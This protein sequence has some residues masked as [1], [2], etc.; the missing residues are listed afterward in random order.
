M[1]T[2]FIKKRKED[3]GVSPDD[4]IFRGEANVN[5]VALNSIEYN[6]QELIESDIKQTQLN[7]LNKE[8]HITWLNVDS[9]HDIDLLEDITSSF[10]IDQL[11]MSEVLNVHSRPRLIDYGTGTLISIRMLQVDEE[12]RIKAENLSLVFTKSI[13]IS[14][15]E[16]PGDVF[17]PIRERLRKGKKRIRE[18]GTDYLLFTLLDIVIDNYL[19]GISIL[20]SKIEALEESFLL[21]ANKE[22]LND[23]NQYKKELNYLRKNILPAK[24]MIISLVKTDSE[25]INDNTVLHLRELQSNISQAI[26]STNSYRE[27]LSDQINI[28]HTLTSARLNDIMKFLTVFS[29]VFIPLTF[30][31][32]IYGTNFDNVPELHYQYSYHV[33]WGV[34]VAVAALMLLYFK[35]KDWL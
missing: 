27:I 12:G 11:A 19:Y 15:Q 18:S 25:L 24:E 31:A 26:D 28:H 33:M 14:F 17:E 4:L 32:G 16:R 30:I 1:I 7:Q 13:L 10:D 5:E 2:R 20:G 21:G 34:M 9:L 29:V 6:P 22:I 23:I 8:N 3:I 35:K